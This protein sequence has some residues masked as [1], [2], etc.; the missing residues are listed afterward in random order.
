V[1]IVVP[2]VLRELRHSSLAVLPEYFFATGGNE[3]LPVYLL[4]LPACAA[5]GYSLGMVFFGLNSRWPAVTRWRSVLRLA[6]LLLAAGVSLGFLGSRLRNFERATLERRVNIR[7]TIS[8]ALQVS[9]APELF[10]EEYTPSRTLPLL[11][12]GTVVE[13]LDRRA[14]RGTEVV[15]ADTAPPR[16]RDHYSLVGVEKIKV[17]EGIDTGLEGWVLV[18][19]LSN[20][21]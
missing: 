21:D 10:C 16:T 6:V 9:P 3:G 12:R 7:L 8:E 18:S 17:V 15:A 5:A 19:G 11:P 1:S 20:T 4:T 14:C 2:D 13:K